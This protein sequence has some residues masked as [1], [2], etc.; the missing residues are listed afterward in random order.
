V[1]NHV[2]K[3]QASATTI[4]AGGYAA[5]FAAVRYFQTVSEPDA[6]SSVEKALAGGALQH[7]GW[8]RFYFGD[9]RWEWS[10]EVAELH[11][12]RP[13]AV[14]P[15]TELVLSHKHPDDH[16]QVAATLDD[17]RRTHKPFSTRHRII[18]VQG[19]TRV[20]VVIGERLHDDS[21]EVIGTQ[22]FYIDATPTAQARES[23]ITAALAELADHRAA[24]EQAKGVLMYVYRIDAEAAFEVLRWRSQDRNVKLRALAEQVLADVGTLTHDEHSLPSRPAF[25]QLLLTAHRRIN[26]NAA[27]ELT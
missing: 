24:I 12:Y 17:I 5:W 13:R 19:D 22:G 2:C 8:Y 4:A 26:A 14:T 1:R 25:D 15:T 6:D 11:G 18:T 10:D 27:D 16:A 21:G 20:V 3:R 23:N 9:E 7:I